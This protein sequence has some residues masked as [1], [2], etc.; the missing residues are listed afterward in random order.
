MRRNCS[1]TDAGGRGAFDSSTTGPCSRRKRRNASAASG[2]G[3]WPLCTT[4]QISQIRASWSCA[5]SERPAIRRG[6]DIFSGSHDPGK[7]STGLA[8]LDDR[9]AL[10]LGFGRILAHRARLAEQEA[11]GTVHGIV[12][13][14]H[15]NLFL[16][17]PL[18]DEVETMTGEKLLEI[19]GRDRR[20]RIVHA[21]RQDVGAHL[22]VT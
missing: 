13:Q 8:E 3:A 21:A 14:L 4:P 5:T 2:K 10:A 19:F 18:G 12:Q 22:Q 16:L 20:A 17:D 1:S 7:G 6:W 15:H 9:S 11:L